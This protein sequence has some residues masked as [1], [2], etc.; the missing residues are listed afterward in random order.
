VQYRVNSSVLYDL[1]EGGFRGVVDS[2]MRSPE[3]G[4]RSPESGVLHFGPLGV[5]S[6]SNEGLPR[7]P[8][9]DSISQKIKKKKLNNPPVTTGKKNYYVCYLAYLV[10]MNVKITK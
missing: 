2:G 9:S 1:G 8:D 10:K 6:P 3:S 4:V 5:R 7:T